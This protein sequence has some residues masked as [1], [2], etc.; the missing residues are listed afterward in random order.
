M[1]AF[2]ALDYRFTFDEITKNIDKLDSLYKNEEKH[3]KDNI[4]TECENEYECINGMF[5]CVNCGEVEDYE[6]I[7][8]W[9]ENMWLNWKKS[10][11]IRSRHIRARVEQNVHANYC[12]SIVSDFM[13]VVE[14]MIKHK[15]INKNV[16]RYDYYIIRLAS[17]IGAKLTKKP[18]N[19]TQ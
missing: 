16:S 9:V 10:Q 17:W 14:I 2:K 4:C 3:T 12:S 1:E 8:E 7:P 11:Y 19:L 6:M 18:T 13:E 15:M 5:A